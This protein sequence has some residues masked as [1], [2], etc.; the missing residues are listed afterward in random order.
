MPEK[1]SSTFHDMMVLSTQGPWGDHDSGQNDADRPANNGSGGNEPPWAP[2]PR[3]GGGNEP[4]NLDDMIRQAQQRFRGGFGAPPRRGGTGSMGASKLFAVLA[5]LAV[6]LWLGSGF[7]LIQPQENAAL[8]TF[9]K[10]SAVK[11]D[12][13]LS[14]HLPFPIQAVEK[15]AVTQKNQMDIGFQQDTATSPQQ[16][17]PAE[18][19]MLTTDDSGDP[20][21]V[22]VHFTVY[23][24]ISNLGDY[25]YEIGDPVGTLHNVAE[26]VMREN[27]GR[28][29]FQNVMQ[30][31]RDEIQNESQERIQKVMDDY[32]SGIAI[33]S[34]NLQHTD[35]PNE[36]VESY[37]NVQN[38]L[39]NK[40]QF[41]NEGL[42]YR[43]KVLQVAQGQAAQ[44]TAKAQAYKE[45]T[46]KRAQGDADRFNLVYAAYQK[47]KDVTA[48]RL[49]LE[50]MEDVLKNN[51]KVIMTGDGAKNM[52]LLPYMQLPPLAAKQPAQSDADTTAAMPPQPAQ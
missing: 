18:S 49:Y 41:K 51:R 30:G 12:P 45:V 11:K 19:M 10:L 13:G 27:V 48:E 14:Y 39:Q 26:S 4:P 43:N 50:T 16:D 20:N 24:H 25:L 42:T 2:P 23:W 6:L 1:N 35:P 15:R 46:V 36:V 21:I 3:R 40:D 37:N 31:G 9:G 44:I 5:L 7:Y 34:V 28:K 8:L 33:D 29:T 38:A 52:P 17:I 32:K 22:K 47:S